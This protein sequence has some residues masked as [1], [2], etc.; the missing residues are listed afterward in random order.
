MTPIEALDKI[1]SLSKEIDY[2]NNLYYQE[3]WSEIS[4]FDFDKL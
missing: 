1:N 2:H 3:N 4:D